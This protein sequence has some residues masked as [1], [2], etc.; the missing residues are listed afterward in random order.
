MYIVHKG[1]AIYSFI[2]W[3]TDWFPVKPYRTP[4]SSN[5]QYSA[6]QKFCGVFFFFFFC[7]FFYSTFFFSIEKIVI[8]G[9]K[10]IYPL[11]LHLQKCDTPKFE[12]VAES[13]GC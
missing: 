6:T 10:N 4:P 7:I 2:F 12:F 3:S 5:I 11:L 13:G 9:V 1:A 8:L